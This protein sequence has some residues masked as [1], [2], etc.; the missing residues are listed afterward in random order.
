MRNLV[1]FAIAATV[2]GCASQAP[3]TREEIIAKMAS[4]TTDNLCVVTIREPEVKELAEA[5]LGRR[6]ATCDWQK[7]DLILRQRQAEAQL[8][9]QRQQAVTA[10]YLQLNQ[11]NQQF[12]QQMLQ[13]Q[14]NQY[15]QNRPVNCTT[16]Y[17]GNQAHTTCR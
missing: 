9:Q 11:Q 1:L 5:E 16:S 2:F 17:F 13:Q 15:R 10:A 14:Q 4:D 8:E 12:Q 6:N 7:I 3:L